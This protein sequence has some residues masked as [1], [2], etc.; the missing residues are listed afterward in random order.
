MR[1][2]LIRILSVVDHSACVL[3]GLFRGHERTLGAYPRPDAAVGFRDRPR[4]SDVRSAGSCSPSDVPG[5][6]RALQRPTD[7]G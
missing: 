5:A 2:G 4:P 3:L 7:C 1:S 6:S